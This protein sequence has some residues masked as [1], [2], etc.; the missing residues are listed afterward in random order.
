MIVIPIPL[1]KI[2]YSKPIGHY[3]REWGCSYT[4]LKSKLKRLGIF[5]RFP[6][7]GG[8]SASRFRA[9]RLRREYADNPKICVACQKPLSYEQ[10]TYSYCSHSCSTSHYQ[11]SHPEKMKQRSLE[12]RRRMAEG[13][14]KKPNPPRTPKVE[15]VMT[16]CE[17]CSKS[18]EIY[19]IQVGKRR[20]CS[21]M[22][23]N[24][25]K[26]HG[27]GGYREGSG[28]GKSGW[29]KGYYCA[30]SWELAW[31]IYHIDHGIAFT[32]N[33]EQFP[34]QFEGKT[35]YYIPDYIMSDG[36]Y[37]EIKGYTS[38]QWRAKLTQFPH[39]IR[40]LYKA[41]MKPILDYVCQRYGYDYLRLYEGNP[42]NKRHNACVVCGQPAIRLCCSR[43][44]SGKR[45][46]SLSP[47]PGVS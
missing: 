16:L 30:S 21:K 10:R 25:G 29:Y 6:N 27:T 32:K 45:A 7:T 9:E 28:R 13:T 24:K 11:A 31:V 17:Y 37:L 23:S 22:C 36:S 26:T 1:D 40:V 18:F 15:R 2:D 46:K 5:D 47:Y 38:A 12:V 19:P 14:W 41:D 3:A 39:P 20:F 34:Y 35:H 8:Q 44:C 4:G 33:A 42:H 43:V